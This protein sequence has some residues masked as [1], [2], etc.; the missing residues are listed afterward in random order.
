MPAAYFSACVAL[1]L[2]V[3]GSHPI[4]GGTATPLFPVAQISD[5]G[6]CADI[7]ST[8]LPATS[9]SFVT[10]IKRHGSIIKDAIRAKK[11]ITAVN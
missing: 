10:N 2:A 11:T 6:L 5:L 7:L 9:D 8:K 4:Y 3:N 1:I